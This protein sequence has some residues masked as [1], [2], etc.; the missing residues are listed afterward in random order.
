MGY[1]PE[2]ILIGLLV[3]A[4]C[5]GIT[6]YAVSQLLF[7]V[8]GITLED[9]AYPYLIA[10]IV[11]LAIAGVSCANINIQG[12]RKIVRVIAGFSTGALLGFFYGGVAL[13]NNPQAA[14]VTASIMGG[15]TATSSLVVRTRL[16]TISIC[17]AGSLA[18]YGLCFLSGTR[19]MSLLSLHKFFLGGLWSFFSLLSLGL[20]LKIIA[21]IIT[22]LQDF[23]HTSWRGAD[24]SSATFI[25]VKLSKNKMIHYGLTQDSM[26][27]AAHIPQSL[28]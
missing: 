3:I 4:D 11:F 16:I 10:L 8:L 14:I 5:G 17:T 21:N 2:S 18:A 1:G 22:E 24:L 15:I 26:K 13:G 20:T 19:A 6:F 25:S 9:P 23:S 28:R 12:P 27:T 7:G